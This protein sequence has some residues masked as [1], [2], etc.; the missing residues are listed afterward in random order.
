MRFWQ[1]SDVNDLAFGLIFNGFKPL[2]DMGHLF[3]KRNH[4]SIDS[5]QLFKI[6]SSQFCTA[7]EME[8]V[9]ELIN[10]S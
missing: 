10:V 7:H 5:I 8:F 6:S 1:R 2:V 3:G 9:P 4:F